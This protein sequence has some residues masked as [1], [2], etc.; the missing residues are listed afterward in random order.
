MS[1]V[2]DVGKTGLKLGPIHYTL[3]LL[4]TNYLVKYHASY[5]QNFTVGKKDNETLNVIKVN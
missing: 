1:A 2:H 3:P 4:S 5:I